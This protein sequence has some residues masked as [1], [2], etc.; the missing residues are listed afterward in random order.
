[1]VSYGAGQ[2]PVG[3]VG[4]FCEL[5]PVPLQTAHAQ[6]SGIDA[7]RKETTCLTQMCSVEV[8]GVLTLR[9]PVSNSFRD[10]S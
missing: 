7:N 1:M 10:P 3:G 2:H 9:G 5:T 4:D 8:N 6:D